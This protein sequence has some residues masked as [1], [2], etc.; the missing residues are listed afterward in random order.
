MKLN[1]PRSQLECRTPDGKSISGQTANHCA[2]PV[3]L[4]NPS[5]PCK[6]CARTF[7]TQGAVN[8]HMRAA[9]HE[10]IPCKRCARTFNTQSAANDH[11]RAAGHDKPNISCK[12]CARKFY[13][14][15]AANEHR[16]AVKH[17]SPSFSCKTCT[18]TFNTQGA[19]NDH[20]RAAGHENISCKTCAKKFLT[21]SA[22]DQHITATKHGSQTTA[23]NTHVFSNK[24][25]SSTGKGS[26]VITDATDHATQ[27]S[28]FEPPNEA[29]KTSSPELSLARTNYAPSTT[30]TTPARG[31]KGYIGEL[32]EQLFGVVNCPGL[33]RD[34]LDRVSRLLPDLLRAFAVQVGYQAPSPMHRDVMYYVRKDRM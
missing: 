2:T 30:L 1:D 26:E 21:Q 15:S 5:F 20:M 18:K 23:S 34:A 33:T 32:A 28:A 11:M 29:R 25:W 27:D 22:A 14:Q 4:G 9:G 12:S 13:T 16:R 10:I 17:G 6:T 3:E 24:I 31:D 7:N 8:D 19:A